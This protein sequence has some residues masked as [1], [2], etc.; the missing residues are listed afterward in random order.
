MKGRGDIQMQWD[1][2]YKVCTQTT[3]RSSKVTRYKGQG[4]SATVTARTYL[5]DKEGAR[6]DNIQ[7]VPEAAIEGG[8]EKGERTRDQLL[9]PSS[10][11]WGAP[12]HTSP[13]L[14]GPVPQSPGQPTWLVSTNETSLLSDPG[15]AFPV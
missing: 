7:E 3:H 8:L 9:Q 14:S 13:Q 6:V 1:N 4:A 12:P 10:N 15:A 5:S 11:H 2:V